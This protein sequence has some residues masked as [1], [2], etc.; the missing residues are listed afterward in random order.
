MFAVD[1]YHAPG[2]LAAISSKYL[3]R[4]RRRTRIPIAF[5]PDGQRN[6]CRRPGDHRV[7][8]TCL[9]GAPAIREWIV[10]QA[11]PL[12]LRIAYHSFPSNLLQDAAQPPGSY[13]LARCYQNCYFFSAL[14]G[15]GCTECQLAIIIIFD[16]QRVSE[17]FTCTNCGLKIRVS[18]VQ[19]RP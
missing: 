11:F 15:V 5:H 17:T 14:L 2:I 8:T 10:G 13:P 6:P 18:P 16:V 12:L 19:S 9:R 7:S 4:S 3:R 1:F